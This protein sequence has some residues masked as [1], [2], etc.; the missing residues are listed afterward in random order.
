[1]KISRL[2]YLLYLVSILSITAAG[3]LTSA[4]EGGLTREEALAAAFPD[5]Q[6]RA[7]MIFLTEAQQKEAA[8][9]SGVEIPTLLIA[10]YS[11]SKGDK[12]LGRAYID[13]HVVRD[14]KQSLLI[15]VDADGII[16]RIEI[17]AFGEPSE[18]QA[19]QAWYRQYE[20][21]ALSSDLYVDR[22]IA[23]IAGATLTVRA[24]NQAVRR[25]LAIDRI[26]RGKAEGAP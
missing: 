19:S 26:L 21:K 5:A 10:R 8:S 4:G 17:T 14:K 12:L 6:I 13:T 1:M 7:E 20:G 11:A 16:Q 24:V 3:R 9:L 23:P 18:Y 22:A 15:I 2:V 25:V